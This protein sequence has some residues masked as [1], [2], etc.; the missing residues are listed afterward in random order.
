[1]YLNTVKLTISPITCGIS[2]QYS[3]ARMHSPVRCSPL[4]DHYSGA[5]RESVSSLRVREYRKLI[6][7]SKSSSRAE[8]Q[9][10]SK[11]EDNCCVKER[12]HWI[13]WIVPLDNQRHCCNDFLPPPFPL[14]KPP[15]LRC[16]SCFFPLILLK[17]QFEWQALENDGV[18]RS[19]LSNS[20][21]WVAKK[22]AR[23]IKGRNPSSF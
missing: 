14:I 23:G 22:K 1:M 5:P 6:F 13:N 17:V 4:I 15:F 9:H 2:K 7:L 19:S 8:Q 16:C 21:G 12:S 11:N 10:H 3:I 18:W 20:N